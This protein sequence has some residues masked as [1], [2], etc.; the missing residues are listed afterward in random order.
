MQCSMVIERSTGGIL[1]K[2]G[3]GSS[4][5]ATNATTISTSSSTAVAMSVA[6]P[7][8]VE[9]LATQ[10]GSEGNSKESS[11]DTEDLAAMVWKYV[12]SSTELVQSLDG[13][14]CFR[15]ESFLEIAMTVLS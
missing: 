15:S 5:H 7:S 1:L 6:V 12:N 8:V 9:D 13:E 11:R 3:H 2:T 4:F 14:V 10:N